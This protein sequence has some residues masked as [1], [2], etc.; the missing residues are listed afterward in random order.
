MRQY[1]ITLGRPRSPISR[2]AIA[3]HL[4]PMRRAQMTRTQMTRTQ[5]GRTQSGRTQGKRRRGD[6]RRGVPAILT[7]IVAATGTGN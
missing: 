7:L 5:M 1:T 4:R 3:E 2:A 6:A